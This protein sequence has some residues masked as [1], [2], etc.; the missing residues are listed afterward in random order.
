MVQKFLTQLENLA[1]K[2][3]YRYM[4]PKITRERVGRH[5]AFFHPRPTGKIIL[6]EYKKRLQGR[7]LKDKS[8][9]GSD[10]KGK[11]ILVTGVFDILH[12][13]HKKFLRAAKNLGGRLLVG[14]ETDARVKKLKG[15]DRPI[16]SLPIR[17]DH[18]RRLKIADA[19]FNLPQKF[20]TNRDWSAFIKKLRPDILAASSSTPHLKNK[21]RIMKRFGGRVVVVLPHNPKV[22]T[23]KVLKSKHG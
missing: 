14:V 1:F 23:T 17:L 2:F 22:S 20:D 13:E 16:N 18:L 10:P 9:K 3:Q 12:S 11:V 5:Y 7:T 15:P 6:E 21:R 8:A 19:V 4:K